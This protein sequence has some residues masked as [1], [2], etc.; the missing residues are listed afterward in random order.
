MCTQV[1]IAKGDG[2]LVV[3]CSGSDGITVNQVRFLPAATPNSDVDSYGG[4]AF[5]VLDDNVTETF[6]DYLEERKINADLGYFVFAYSKDKEQ[7]EYVH[8]LK[9]V[10]AFVAK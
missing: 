4:P 8:W 1:T 10:Q 2:K 9:K 5:D 7:R 6:L 3:L